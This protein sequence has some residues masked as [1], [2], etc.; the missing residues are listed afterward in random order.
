[1][2]ANSQR[3]VYRIHHQTH[4]SYA[5]PVRLSHQVLHLTP[6]ELPWQQ[7]LSH[8]VNV[9]PAP[10]LVRSYADNFGNIIKAFSL[11]V[12]HTSLDVQADSWVALTPRGQ[13]QES[14]A[15]DEAATLMAYHGGRVMT[16]GML[17]ASN[18]LFESSHVRIKREF[19]RYAADCFVPGMSV[20]EGVR[21][22]MM[23]IY[24]EFA[25][26]PAATTV[27]TPVTEVF[28]NR[29]GVCQD[30][31]HLMLSC[32]RSIGLAARYVSGYLL[33]EP[34]P[35]QPRLIGADA[36]HAWVSVY[37]PG[38]EGAEGCWIDAD[39]TNGIFPDTSHITLGWGRDF[40]DIS[41]LRGV[42]IGGGR[43]T[44]QVA[45]TVMPG[46]EARGLQLSI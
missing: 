41:P 35:G 40:L 34:P 4:Y 12:D 32:L 11:D 31:A 16:P 15:W 24:A 29:R 13:P 28:A 33:T 22:L 19:I 1:M 6:R 3:V 25:F 26:D 45:V 30:F 27:S 20:V 2:N 17:D 5:L 37:C 14:M 39:P 38:A 10:Q 21:A 7:C 23:R 18:F 8:T 46:E 44:M 43:Q 36:S 9:L 42:L